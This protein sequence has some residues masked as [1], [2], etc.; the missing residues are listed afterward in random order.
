MVVTSASIVIFV[1]LTTLAT[2]ILSKRLQ[3]I[4][5]TAGTGSSFAGA[6]ATLL[7]LTEVGTKIMHCK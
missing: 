2:R 6:G 3:T 1:L 5:I 7:G 4:A